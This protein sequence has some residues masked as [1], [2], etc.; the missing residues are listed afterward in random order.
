MNPGPG[1]CDR[2]RREA[3]AIRSTEYPDWEPNVR[4]DGSVGIICSGCLTNEQEQAIADD[5][6]ETMG[7]SPRRVSASCQTTRTT[8]S[9]EAQKDTLPR[10]LQPRQPVGLCVGG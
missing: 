10:D 2:C 3:P 4:D 5:L 7:S 8:G 6:A 1:L 9:R